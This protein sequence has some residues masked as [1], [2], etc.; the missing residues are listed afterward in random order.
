MNGNVK[1]KD[2][3]NNWTIS[4]RWPSR[5]KKITFNQVN[6]LI[7]KNEKAIKSTHNLF[8]TLAVLTKSGFFERF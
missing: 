4:G 2:K 7:H 3:T 8:S 5:L 6:L 1:A